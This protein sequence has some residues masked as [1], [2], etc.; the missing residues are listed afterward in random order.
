VKKPILF[1]LIAA[2]GLTVGLYSLPKVVVQNT[3]KQLSAA[4]PDKTSAA[5][6]EPATANGKANAQHNEPL[7]TKQQ[8]ELANLRQQLTT[9]N[10]T[11]KTT[12]TT[13]LIDLL[14][15][16][17]RFDSAAYY[18]GL[19]A[20]TDPTELNLLRAGDVYFEAFNFALDEKKAAELGQ[21]T[22]DFYT[23]VLA[24]NPD[25]LAVKANLAMTYVSTPNPMQGIMLLREVLQ[26]DP[27]NELALFNLGM[28]SMRSGQYGKAVERFRQILVTNPDNRKARFYLG[29][30][31]VETGQKA[32]AKTVLAQVKANEKDP[33]ILAAVREL[34]EKLN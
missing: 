19:L 12:A 30:S 10:V 5:A 32:E 6:T 14:R 1:V 13:R 9:T 17:N 28:L 29:V 33:Q 23:Q 20:K 34:E 22:R 26:Q 18:A 24:K 8:Q 2:A 31:L 25:L 3:E 21:K 7:S 27:T 11:A 4:A 16:L 15:S